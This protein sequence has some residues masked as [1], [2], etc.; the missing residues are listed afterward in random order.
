MASPES[1]W[2]RLPAELQ[3]MVVAAAGPMAQW[4]VWRTVPAGASALPG[5][6]MQRMWADAIDL[7]WQ[8][9]LAAL[10]LCD[11][12]D[13]VLARVRSPEMLVRLAAL[14]SVCDGWHLSIAKV[15]LTNGWLDAFGHFAKIDQLTAIIETG[16][17]G[18]LAQYAGE[19]TETEEWM[20]KVLAGRAAEDGNVAMLQEIDDIVPGSW[21]LGRPHR[22]IEAATLAVIHGQA[23]AV[24]WLIEKRPE[25]FTGFVIKEAMDSGE[26]ALLPHVIRSLPDIFQPR[27]IH[28]AIH[29]G[30][31]DVLIAMIDVSADFFEAAHV[32]DA[33]EAGDHRVVA[34]LAELDPDWI[35]EMHLWLAA[36]LGRSEILEWFIDNG[37]AHFFSA[38]VVKAGLK[39]DDV[40]AWM[41]RR[42]E[43]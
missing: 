23:E 32:D 13:A 28:K 31:I 30:F 4:L 41:R 14:R 21:R 3:H 2:D 29:G 35:K 34:L 18:M 26:V 6:D 11:V 1:Q 25:E 33:I 15:A 19:L 16:S 9:D 5:A 17:L 43:A 12:D 39:H 38:A 36:L 42:L 20:V 27:H 10:P 37:Y 7:D 8:G 40:I 24:D 22:D